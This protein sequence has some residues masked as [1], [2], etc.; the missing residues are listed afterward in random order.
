MDTRSRGGLASKIHAVVDGNG[1]P[2][3]IASQAG[4]RTIIDLRPS[5]R[6]SRTPEQSAWPTGGY[7]AD[8]IRALAGQHGAWANVPPRRNRNDTLCFSPYLYRARN[9]VERFFSEIKQCRRATTSSRRTTSPSSSLPWYAY[10]CALM[11]PR[12]SHHRL[13]PGLEDCPQARPGECNRWFVFPPIR[14]LPSTRKFCCGAGMA[15]SDTGLAQ[16]HN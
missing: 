5:S 11:S 4:K 13:F 2:I 1:L 16:A 3:Q 6:H 8:W 10:S 14:I 7:D 9:L 15:V 12:P